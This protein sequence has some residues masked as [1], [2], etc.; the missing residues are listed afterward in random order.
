MRLVTCG[1]IC[2]NPGPDSTNANL[3]R[4]KQR[5]QPKLCNIK[6]AHLNIHSLKNREHYMLAKEIVLAK[7]LDIFT[8]S[9]TW[10]DD[11]ASD[12]EVEFAGF[13]IYRLDREP[14]VGGGVCVFVK[15]DFKVDHLYDLSRYC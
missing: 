3:G 6:I 2:P 8:V 5:C 13:N 12:L 14:K 4:R 9:E 15:Q 7:K 10:L 11:T 1:S